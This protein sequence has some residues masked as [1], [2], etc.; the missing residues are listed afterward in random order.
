MRKLGFKGLEHIYQRDSICPNKLFAVY[1]GV[2]L[3]V[4][5]KHLPTSPFQG[6]SAVTRFPL[7]CTLFSFF[8]TDAQSELNFTG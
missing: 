7:L 3:S 5:L 6:G 1:S 4:F 8:F 2:A